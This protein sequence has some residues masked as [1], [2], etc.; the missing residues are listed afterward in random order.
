MFLLIAGK[1]LCR[2]RLV[3]LSQLLKT[4]GVCMLLLVGIFTGYVAL[5]AP[6]QLVLH[7]V[8][9]DGTSVI[10]LSENREKIWFKDFPAEVTYVD[11]PKDITG[12]GLQEILVVTARRG[13]Q[14][15]QLFLLN[16]KGDIILDSS[17][18]VS[19]ILDEPPYGALVVPDY[20]IEK[21]ASGEAIAVKVGDQLLKLYWS[22]DSD[23]Y[24]AW[25]KPPYEQLRFEPFQISFVEVVD[26]AKAGPKR[27][28]FIANPAYPASS[29]LVAVVQLVGNTGRVSEVRGGTYWHPGKLKD[30]IVLPEYPNEESGPLVIVTAVN[31]LL[32]RASGKSVNVVFALEGGKLD[33]FNCWN[34]KTTEV[35]ELFPS[36]EKPTV[37]PGCSDYQE[38][39]RWY[40]WIEPLGTPVVGIILSHTPAPYG[41]TVQ[42]QGGCELALDA[43]S[44]NLWHTGSQC[45]PDIAV[46][47]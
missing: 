8:A 39:Q 26:T 9:K 33:R 44:G 37:V 19:V 32:S 28:I 23:I 21:N 41:V 20:Q 22:V 13:T 4:L 14:A 27:I 43:L 5:Q 7:S 11:G 1:L 34:V 25:G 12:D 36:Y 16:Q 17:R 42:L 47:P 15:S 29:S 35:A 40:R 6:P 10:A 45:P 3:P 46:K 24:S 18:L 30:V 31:E 38:V 2:P